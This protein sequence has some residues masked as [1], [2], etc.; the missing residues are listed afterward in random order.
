LS[1]LGLIGIVRSLNGA[2]VSNEVPARKK[3][4]GP[5]ADGAEEDIAG[6][7]GHVT[8]E[9]FS[10]SCGQHSIATADKQ[11]TIEKSTPASPLGT[12]DKFT[13]LVRYSVKEIKYL[14]PITP[15]TC[16]H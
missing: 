4:L 5:S 11:A 15:S 14:F 1:K 3:D 10:H 16:D 9:K 8:A 6:D 13:G 7:F 12:P 2:E